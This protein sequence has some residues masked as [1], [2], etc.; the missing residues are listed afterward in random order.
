MAKGGGC[1]EPELHAV[2]DA[3][4]VLAPRHLVCVL[5]E[6]SAADPMM[7]AVLSTAKPA[8][9]ALRLIDAD[10]IV[11]HVFLTMVDPARV[12][13]RVQPLPGVRFVGMNDRARRDVLA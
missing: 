6:V 1:H 3:P 9:I 2:R 13:G 10:S 4:V 8:E 5:V 7:D 11:S 12:I